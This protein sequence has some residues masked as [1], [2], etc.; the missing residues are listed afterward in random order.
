MTSL[1]RPFVYSSLLIATWCSSAQVMA[2][3]TNPLQN[4]LEA[5]VTATSNYVWRGVALSADA[6][7]QG[8]VSVLDPSGIHADF[9]T[10]NVTG[11]TELDIT[12]GYN[13]RAEM[14]NYDIGGKLY[15]LPQYES[16]NFVE[17]FVGIT[18]GAFGAKV[19]LSPDSG[20]YLEGHVTLPALEYWDLTL[21]AGHYAI[22]EDDRG[23]TIAREDYIDFSAAVSRVYD[24]MRVEFKITGTNLD[25][26][27]AMLPTDNFRTIVSL[28]KKFQP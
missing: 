21:H 10:S 7:L 9:F 15:Y 22:D 11:G 19:S 12:A 14:F 24:G 20:T 8:K 18:I 1:R 28:S 5:E 6:A 25:D 16:S 13:G 26:N 27:E 2:A 23:V 3:Q 4:K 17:I